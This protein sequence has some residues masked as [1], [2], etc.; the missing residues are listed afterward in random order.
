MQNATDDR[1]QLN[2]SE[3]NVIRPPAVPVRA[4]FFHR[5]NFSRTELALLFYRFSGVFFYNTILAAACPIP[6]P[7]HRRN[8]RHDRNGDA[9]SSP[10]LVVHFRSELA[11]QAVTEA[12]IA[13]ATN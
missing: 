9:V 3:P 5:R 12:A 2:I 13:V 10:C 4:L 1:K 8:R 11:G 7:F 6:T